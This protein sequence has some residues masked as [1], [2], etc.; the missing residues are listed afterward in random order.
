[1][2]RG[3]RQPT[4]R[5]EGLDTLK[6]RAVSVELL[7]TPTWTNASFESALCSAIEDAGAGNLTELR[8]EVKKGYR[9]G[10]F[11]VPDCFW[12]LTEL[13][14]LTAYN[15]ILLGSAQSGADTLARL[16]ATLRSLSIYES[17]ILSPDSGNALGYTPYK[18]DWEA[19]FASKPVMSVLTLINNGIEGEMPLTLPNILRT[20]TIN[21]NPLLAGSIP[22]SL[23]SNY[24]DVDSGISVRFSGN[25]LTGAIPD[26]L[27][28]NYNST[29]VYDLNFSRNA[30]SGTLPAALFQDIAWADAYNPIIDLSFNQLDGELPQIFGSNFWGASNLQ[31]FLNDNKFSGSIPDNL[32]D[33]AGRA[34]NQVYLDLSGNELSGDIPNLFGQVNSNLT[35][36]YLTV[37]VG[38][39]QL[40][41][42]I[43]GSRLWAPRS[44]ANTA[45]KLDF[46]QNQLSGT[47]PADLFDSVP[48][49][50]S[51]D[52]D[53]SGN[54][55]LGSVNPNTFA[56]A[57]F[58]TPASL[59]LSLANNQLSGALT[60]AL[61]G[62]GSHPFLNFEL[63]LSSNALGG[64]IPNDLFA[65]YTTASSI[66][67]T[68]LSLNLANCGFTG[69]L[70]ALNVDLH[71]LTLNLDANNFNAISNAT[72]ADYLED[73]ILGVS[74]EFTLSAVNNSLR[75]AL[76]LP[77][78]ASSFPSTNLNFSG[79]NLSA[80]SF[81]ANIGY[82]QT[83]VVANNPSMTGT[84]PVRLFD[85]S[86]NIKTFIA[87]ATSLSGNFPDLS[88]LQN[89]R[90]EVL[91]LN[92]TI[93]NYCPS[94]WTSPWTAS[95]LYI[96]GLKNTNAS[97]CITYYPQRCQEE[98]IEDP[99]PSAL[100]AEEP[101]SIPSSPSASAPSEEPLA[102]VAA[103]VATPVLVPRTSTP[104]ST[105]SLAWNAQ[106]TICVFVLLVVMLGF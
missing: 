57:R 39:N 93:I 85:F 42:S 73:A 91:D 28:A 51:I 29:R 12:T 37:L 26:D 99:S 103:P 77:D 79:N 102:P 67:T 19:L 97:D 11:Y 60:A 58:D 44:L 25:G 95:Q 8:I 4:T 43:Q 16:P 87:S 13:T 7:I 92:D 49:T 74:T 27:F 52:L 45:L 17:R 6:T 36:G 71:Y 56:N 64:T 38:R 106:S 105:T 31:Y 34:M 20:L 84:L 66:N 100:P 5:I 48:S 89:S 65:A 32:F 81:E 76:S 90:L 33:T 55:L 80:L 10:L 62:S 1:M 82:L 72:W 47:V 88:G 40:T 15:V 69:T 24:S 68:S 101:S 21:G 54:Q 53:L 96:C 22:S 46:S 41:G 2:L 3:I 94:T 50:R 86:S 59:A 35:I 63:D 78:H 83:L 9:V 23:F 98:Y 30:L 14:E 75:G 104:S 61:I 18:A 70:P